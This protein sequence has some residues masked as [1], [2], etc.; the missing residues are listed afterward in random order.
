MAEP[1]RPR[2][3]GDDLST[4]GRGSGHAATI[5]QPQAPWVAPRHEPQVGTRLGKYLLTAK[6]GQGAEGLVYRALHPTLNISVAI[7]VLKTAG[8]EIDERTYRQFT[9]EA[10]TLAQLNHPNIVRVI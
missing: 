7:K 2:S 8:R 3:H 10:Q 5:P 9:A 6:I 4:A 1:L